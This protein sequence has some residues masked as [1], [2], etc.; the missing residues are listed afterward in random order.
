MKKLLIPLTLAIAIVLGN[1][2]PAKSQSSTATWLINSN[3]VTNLLIGAGWNVKRVTVSAS[4]TSPVFL[5]YEYNTNGGLSL[6]SL[7]YSNTTSFSNLVTVNPYTNSVIFTN[8]LGQ[9]TTN[10]Y[11]GI[12]QYWTNIAEATASNALQIG[13]FAV[14]SG[15]PYTVD[16]NWNIVKG[17]TVRGTNNAN[18][19]IILE[20][21]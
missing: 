13:S 8:S 4:G 9:N 2:N 20:Y 18:S 10:K 11:V 21:Q 7:Q 1:I 17:L 12:Y 5:F 14:Q 16:V 3:V 15:V 19:V 6:G